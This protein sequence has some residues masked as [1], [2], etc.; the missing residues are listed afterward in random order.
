MDGAG[1]HAGP[2]GDLAGRELAVFEEA[3]IG[4]V[5][6]VPQVGGGDAVEGL[7]GAG[8]VP[9]VVER[10]GQGVVVQDGA[11]AAGELDRGGIGGA[12]LDGVLAAGDLDLLACAG[13]PAQP[14]AQ[15][16]GVAGGG[17]EGDVAEQGAQQPLAV[18]VAGGRGRPQGGQIGDGGG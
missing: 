10:G 14:D 12:Q 15:A 9:G 17:G 7:A 4:D 13:F 5:V 6:V 11:D 8:A 16:R 3:G 2:L 18:L 1:G